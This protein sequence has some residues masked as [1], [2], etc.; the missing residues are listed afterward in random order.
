MVTPSPADVAAAVPIP[1]NNRRTFTV[2]VVV[3]EKRNLST[4]GE[5]VIPV[6]CD[7][8]TGYG[9]IGIHVASQWPTAWTLKNKDWILLYS[10]N[11]TATWYRVVYAG[12]DE[13]TDT[14]RISLVGPDWNGGTAATA[15]SVDGVTGVYTS[16]V[17]LN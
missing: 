16:T 10:P 9:G 5:E 13:A 15:I 6:T 2:S 1:W 8:A 11:Q 4:A 14:T 12:Y 17:Q 3:C 7:T